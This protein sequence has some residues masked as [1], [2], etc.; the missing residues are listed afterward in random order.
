VES[1]DYVIKMLEERGLWA[2]EAAAG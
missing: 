2:E 1:A